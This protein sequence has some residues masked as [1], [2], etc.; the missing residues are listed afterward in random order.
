MIKRAT[1]FVSGAVAGAAG[2][3]Y[4]T[5]K[6]TRTVKRT[7]AQLAPPT[8][9][10]SIG[11]RVRSRARDVGEAV[12]DGRA[13]MRA[14]EAELRARRDGR[15]ADLH[16]ELGPGDEILVDGQPARPGQVIVLHPARPGSSGARNHP[17]VRHARQ[18]RRR[19]R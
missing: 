7:A 5:R 3:T 19:S 18:Q 12:R 14:K 13:A 1:W 10:R 6:V 2:S 4:L 9:A 17:A 16:D 11:R 8:L 15:A